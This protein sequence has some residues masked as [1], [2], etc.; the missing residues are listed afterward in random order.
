MSPILIRPVR[1]QLEHDRV[2]RLLLGKWRKKYEA[3]ANPGDERNASLKVRG[4]SL[5][6]D[7][8]LAIPEGG[9]KSQA[10]VEVETSESLN[11]LEALSQWTNFS[12][13][14]GYFYLY[15]PTAG[16]D[17]AKRLAEQHH[18][19]ISE[20]WSY[21]QI[22]DQV[23][24]LQVFKGKG[25]PELSMVDEEEPFRPVRPE[26]EPAEPVEAPSAKSP[27]VRAGG[28]KS[29][30]PVAKV[31]VAKGAAAKAVAAKS[32]ATTAS[33]END[34]RGRASAK[35]PT[36]RASGKAA[37][38]PAVAPQSKKAV[39]PQSKKMVAKPG[40]PAAPSKVK[41]M[42]SAK[43]DKPATRTAKPAQSR[44][45]RSIKP[46]ASTKKATAQARKVAA[47][48]PKRSGKPAR[49]HVAKAAGARTASSKAAPK[50][51]AGKSKSSR[52]RR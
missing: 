37:V 11:H 28:A 13:A 9:K 18:V 50:K 47:R 38:E 44:S 12:K 15:V 8:I 7:L 41:G 1:E 4:A 43:K 16:V 29:T 46:A 40:A 6:P 24:F 42:A 45:V 27:A 39:A 26:P 31:V 23:R 36:G 51:L 2:I 33:S 34:A 48:A 19:N 30:G 52:S 5:F 20:L 21:Y 17:V 35:T 14:K 3:A 22:G 32:G 49:A 10:V 25:T